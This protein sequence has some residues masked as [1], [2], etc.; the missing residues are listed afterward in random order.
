MATLLTMAILPTRGD[1]EGGD[2]L[3]GD[4][5]EIF[6]HAA[7][8]VAVRRDE[9]RL[10]CMV[11]GRGRG[12][13]STVLPAWLGAGAGLGSGLGLARPCLHGRRREGGEFGG[14]WG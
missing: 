8:R 11:R 2:L 4:A 6:E 14:L 3:V 7:D 9:H 5:V 1:L 13:V 12:R 10:A